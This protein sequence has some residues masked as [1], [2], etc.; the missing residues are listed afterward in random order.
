M[1]TILVDSHD[2]AGPFGAKEAGEGP[3]SAVAPS[4]ANAIHDAIGVWIKELPITPDRVL[5]ALEQQAALT[6][7]ELS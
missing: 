4:I 7:A 1:E 3:I 2:P 5:E 6:G